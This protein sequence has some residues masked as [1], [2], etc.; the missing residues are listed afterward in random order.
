V[1]LLPLFLLTECLMWGYCLIRGRRFM[2]AKLATYRWLVQHRGEVSESRRSV[3]AVRVRSDWQLIMGLKWGYAWDQF[4]RLGR[5]RGSARRK[6]PKS[7][8]VP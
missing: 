8:G 2:R 5:E 3:D 4:F 6:I 7:A 1:A